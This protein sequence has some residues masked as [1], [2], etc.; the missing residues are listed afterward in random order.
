MKKLFIFFLFLL[1]ACKPALAEERKIYCEIESKNSVT[2][3]VKS[4][5]SG[6]GFKFYKYFVKYVDNN[7]NSQYWIRISENNLDR[8]MYYL[9]LNVGDKNFELLQ[10]TSPTYSQIYSTTGTPAQASESLFAIY[11]VPQNVIN[12]IKTAKTPI[13]LILNKQNRQ[14]IN[15]NSDIEFTQAIQKII[16][17]EYS[18][19]D[20]YWQPNIKK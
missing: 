7:G 8:F 11:E 19:K 5:N 15:L 16:S 13:T 14:G 4:L 18:D 12:E 2:Y 1:L 10:I 17:L 9:G 20:D 3:Y 6:W